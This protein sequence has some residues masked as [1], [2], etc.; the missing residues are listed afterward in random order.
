MHI[1]FL[2]K[3]TISR[4][5]KDRQKIPK[6]N[7]QKDKDELRNITQ[8]KMLLWTWLKTGSD[9]RYSGRVGICFLQIDAHNHLA[10]VARLLV[11]IILDNL[12]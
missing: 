10:S 11:M 1:I 4:K 9:P 8:F 12:I 7:E 2:N 6:E 3:D 5:S